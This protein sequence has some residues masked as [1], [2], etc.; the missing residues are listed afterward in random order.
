MQA[1][2]HSSPARHPS[3][4]IGTSLG[5]LESEVFLNEDEPEQKA[6]DNRPITPSSTD[7]PSSVLASP[8]PIETGWLLALTR[9]TPDPSTFS[10][11]DV[12]ADPEA[13]AEYVAA[14]IAELEISRGQRTT[15]RLD[16]SPCHYSAY[17]SHE[18]RDMLVIS[19][20]V[21]FVVVIVIAE[22]WEK[23]LVSRRAAAAGIR[24][25][26]ALEQGEA[27]ESRRHR[28][29]IS[30][31]CAWHRMRQ[32]LAR[33]GAIRLEEDNVPTRP[34]EISIRESEPMTVETLD[35]KTELQL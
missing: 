27:I 20:F 2:L 33:E 7:Q 23:V 19:L 3:A 11:P 25:E 14:M 35:E 32:L 4:P 9:P 31:W 22:M 6:F 16:S 15:S 26:E 13:E 34:Q 24:L 29:R 10:A 5:Q 28:R 1:A 30:N 21:T 18:Y 8:Q 17:V 12:L